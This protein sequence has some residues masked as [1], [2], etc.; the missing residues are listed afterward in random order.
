[1]FS[2]GR[3]HH[4][5]WSNGRR[6]AGISTDWLIHLYAKALSPSSQSTAIGA[7]HTKYLVCSLRKRKMTHNGLTSE[8]QGLYDGPIAFDIVVFYVVQES[9]APADHHQKPPAGMMIFFVN[10]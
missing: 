5:C 9:A 6:Q 8:S 2:R 7:V 1:M 10:F 4:C 3:Y